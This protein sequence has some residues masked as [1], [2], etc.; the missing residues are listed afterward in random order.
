MWCNNCCLCFPLRGGAMWLT[1]LVLTIN[2][3]GAIIL[4]LWGPYFFSTLMALL[5]AGFSVLQAGTAGLAF[6]GLC[7]WSYMLTRLFVYIQ[8]LIAFLA[9][10]RIGVMAYQLEKNKGHIAAECWG[11]VNDKGYSPQGTAAAFYCSTPIE[12]FILIFIFGLVMDYVLNLY[13]YF[14]V[15]RFYVRMRLYPFH[16][17]FGLTYEHGLYEI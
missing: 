3:I 14:V 6:L 15:W 16:K 4:F 17:R 7:N 13:M 11:A 5:F 8:W 9:T 1:G 2:G 10:A 12:S